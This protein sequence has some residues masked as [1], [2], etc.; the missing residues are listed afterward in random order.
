MKE[1]NITQQ[2]QKNCLKAKIRE[3]NEKKEFKEER[4]KNKEKNL[5]YVRVF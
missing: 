2:P 3:M 1:M 5:Y 4:E